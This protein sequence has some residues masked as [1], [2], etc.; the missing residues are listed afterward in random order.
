MSVRPAFFFV[1]A[2]CTLDMIGL[3]G[4]VVCS[5]RS[6]PYT[7]LFL[8]TTIHIVAGIADFN[9]IIMYMSGVSKEVG[10]KIFP[11]SEMD[12]PLFYYSYGYSFII[13][14]LGFMC[15]ETAAI[16]LVLVYMSKRD[17]RTYNRYCINTIMRNVRE[18]PNANDQMILNGRYHQHARIH[19]LQRASRWVR[20]ARSVSASGVRPSTRA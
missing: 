13:F 4:V 20:W 17:E 18:G 11:A 14:K 10:N 1:Y 12:D 5:M 16:L 6:K 15:T 8:A 9:S 19:Q 2:A 7:S 3:G